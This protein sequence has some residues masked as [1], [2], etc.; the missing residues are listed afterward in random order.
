MDSEI[1]LERGTANRLLVFLPVF[2]CA[3]SLTFFYLFLFKLGYFYG[4]MANLALSVLYLVPLVFYHLNLIAFGKD[5]LAIMFL[6][7]I[8]MHSFVLFPTESYFHLFLVSAFPLVFMVFDGSEKRIRG[9]Y[10]ITVASLLVVI[11]FFGNDGL[12]PFNFQAD[13]IA[14]VRNGNLIASFLLLAVSSMI[15]VRFIET[16]ESQSSMLATTDVLTG[17]GNRRYFQHLAE[18]QLKLAQRNES[19]LSLLFIDIDDFKDVNDS[20]GHHV[21]DLVL[22]GVA[23]GIR[24]HGRASDVLSRTGGDEFQVLLPGANLQAAIQ[25]AAAMRRT[26]AR[27]CQQ[28]SGMEVRVSIGAAQYEAGDTIEMLSSRADQ[29]LYEDKTGFKLSRDDEPS[30]KKIVG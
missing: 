29:G 19:D 4:G 6:G 17:L 14:L 30:L 13:D 28:V 9:I 12:R 2:G 11:H 7:S 8:V 3:V 1:I 25:V 23:Q 21:G 5:L 16:R 27:E 15:Y 24:T 20:R 18:K 26:I 22:Q 10:A